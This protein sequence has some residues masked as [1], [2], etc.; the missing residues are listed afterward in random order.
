MRKLPKIEIR[1]AD[2]KDLG[3][4]L[5][6]AESFFLYGGTDSDIYDPDIFEATAREYLGLEDDLNKCFVATHEGKVVGYYAITGSYI[7]SRRPIL[8]E[9]HFAVLPEYVLSSAGRDL[10]NACKTYGEQIGCLCFYAGA[11]S[12][13]K[14]FDN[15]LINMY[16][17]LG[18]DECG[19]MM[20]YE[21]G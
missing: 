8:Y 4:I 18:F 10:A 17:K 7:Y 20:R 19:Q 2:I 14:R 15:S 1:E 12:G 13:I 9:A 21:Y 5:T 11:T 6:I 16:S 3:A